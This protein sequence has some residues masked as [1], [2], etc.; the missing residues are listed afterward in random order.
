MPELISVLDKDAIARYVADV[1]KQISDD[2]REGDL[3][4]IGVLKG[5][6]VFMADLIRQ[7][8]LK[9][10]AIDFI[11]LASYGDGVDPA[12]QVRIIH[13]IETDISNKDV[14]IVDDIYDT[15]GTMT[16]LCRHLETHRPRTIRICTFIDKTER[17]HT[18][19][20]PDYAC[21]KIDEGFLV[22]YGLDYAEA[23]RHLPGLY[24]LT[25]D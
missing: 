21:H 5:A 7:L 11:R 22:G 18:P 8:T 15:G 16:F 3:V 4:I 1:A 13:D 17:R 19:L 23:Y 10:F 24:K 6:F 25:C 9:S 12:G 2:Y 14:L 20:Q